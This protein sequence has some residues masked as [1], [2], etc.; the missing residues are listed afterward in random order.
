MAGLA[1]LFVVYTLNF[2][3]RSLVYILFGPIGTELELNDLQLALLGSTSFVLFYTVLGLPFGRLADRVHRLRMIAAGLA[4]WSVAS[5][6]TG[7]VSSFEGLLLCR[8]GVGVGEAT[9]GPAAY[10]LLADWFPPRRRATAAALFAAGIPLGAGLALGLGGYI[11]QHWGWRAAFPALGLPGLLVAL[12]VLS[13]REPARGAVDKQVRAPEGASLGALLRSSKTLRYHL[14]GYAACA[15]G[16]NALSMWVPR[17]LAQHWGRSL[18]EV[19]LAVGLCA[20]IGGLCGTSLGGVLADALQ[21]RHAGGRLVFGA[22]TAAGSAL[23]WLVLLGTE[24]YAVALGATGMGMA[25]GLAWLGPASADI[26]DLVPAEQRGLAISTYYLVVNVVGYGLAPPA[27]GALADALGGP[28][29]MGTALLLCPL[30]SLLAAG[31]LALGS[32][33]RAALPTLAASS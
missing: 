12:V 9:L 17:Y 26:Q 14:L 15:V 1:V 30:A 10:S 11:G 18:A 27:L 6:L 22:L 2:L 23:C 3:D 19:G 20:V 7:L 5:S 4:L 8:I 31:L 33:S 32:R 24:D 13:L 29:T 21:R 16:A 28:E 25:L